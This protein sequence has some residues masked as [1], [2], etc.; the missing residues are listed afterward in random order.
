MAWIQPIHTSGKLC[1]KTDPNYAEVR[2]Q[3]KISYCKRHVTHKM[4]EIVAKL[5]GIPTKD[6]NLYEFDHLIPLGIGGNSSIE[7]LW[8]QPIKEAKEKDKIED[9]AFLCMKNA[10]CT[11]KQAIEMIWNW[12]KSEKQILL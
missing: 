9:A 8:P 11:Q 5:Y 2:Y 3:E 6:W 4:K 12:F 7:N 1:S 10:T